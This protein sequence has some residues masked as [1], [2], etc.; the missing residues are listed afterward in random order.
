MGRVFYIGAVTEKGY[1]VTKRVR[2]EDYTTTI[3][4]VDDNGGEGYTYE[5]A[6]MLSVMYEQER[7]ATMGYKMEGKKLIKVA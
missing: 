3:E 6:L 4:V 5:E 7:F 2:N 1:S